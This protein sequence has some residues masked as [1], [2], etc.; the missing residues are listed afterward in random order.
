MADD[1]ADKT[2]TARVL[3]LLKMVLIILIQPILEVSCAIEE[4][5]LLVSMSFLFLHN[6][7]T[8]FGYDFKFKVSI[9]LILNGKLGLIC[10]ELF[11]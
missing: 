11:Y 3:S 10:I 6:I 5:F 4:C 1:I 7:V 8:P 9:L 2:V